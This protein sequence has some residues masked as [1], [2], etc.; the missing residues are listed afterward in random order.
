MKRGRY[1]GGNRCAFASHLAIALVGS[2]CV[3]GEPGDTGPDN[4]DGAHV[5]D[6]PPEQALADFREIVAA[7]KSS[8][9]PLEYKQAR[10]KIDIDALSLAA[11][12]EL[13]KVT[14]DSAAF[15]IWWKFLRQLQDGHVSL[16]LISNASPVRAYAIPCLATPVQ[17]K[18]LIAGCDATAM[19]GVQR[20]DELLSIGGEAI[21]TV[22]QKALAYTAMGHPDSD[23]HL[24]HYLLLARPAYMVDLVPAGETTTL[25]LARPDGSTYEVTATWQAQQWVDLPPPAAAGKVQAQLPL[26]SRLRQIAGASD[27]TIDSFGAVVPF[28][29][30]DAVVQKFGMTQVKPSAAALSKYGVA[31][32]TLPEEEDA[33]KDGI[34]DVFAATYTHGGK[35]LLLVRIPSY[36]ATDEDTNVAVYRALLDDHD[37]AVDALVIDQTHNPG[38]SV[39]YVEKLFRLFIA[40]PKPR[41]VQAHNADRT[42]LEAYQMAAQTPGLTAE[43]QQIILGYANLIDAAITQGRPLSDRLPVP[44]EG[45]GFDYTVAPDEKYTWRKPVLLLIDELDGSGGDAFPML[46]T[47][48]G[49]A[50]AF[51]QHT[52]GMGGSVETV[53][54]LNHS[55]AQLSLTRGLFNSHDPTGAYP[56]EIENNGIAPAP[57]H[58]HVISVEDFRAGYLAYVAAFSSA[59]TALKGTATCTGAPGQA[60]CPQEPEDQNDPAD[61]P[62]QDCLRRLVAPAVNILLKN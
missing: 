52:A 36:S 25:A 39:S 24:A 27:A 29:I 23:R 54:T 48:S 41:F 1:P 18:A 58:T 10:F 59:A 31:P 15:S 12:A 20:G 47:R 6:L 3:I 14:T 34:P 49:A 4:L 60:G 9:G 16:T 51:G 53:E 57:E 45:T 32:Q 28:F 61:S 26:A 7:I 56:T 55:G 43:Q 62:L 35:K 22:E 8:Y 50:T 19:P 42:W 46:M 33:D 30:N 5:E 37:D 13:A 2:A 11:E 21:A 44:T 17:G 38:G 40:G